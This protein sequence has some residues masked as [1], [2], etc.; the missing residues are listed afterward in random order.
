LVPFAPALDHQQMAATV[1]PGL[2]PK[3]FG[4]VIRTETL[5][6]Q[7]T[8]VL[9]LFPQHAAGDHTINADTR[10]WGRCVSVKYVPIADPEVKLTVLGRGAAG[11]LWLLMS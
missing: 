6:F 8:R 5:T 1:H 10:Y 7:T 2:P 11:G 9:I 3:F 4:R